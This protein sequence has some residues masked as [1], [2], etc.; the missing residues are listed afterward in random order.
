MFLLTVFYVAIRH[1]YS[2]ERQVQAEIFLFYW[3]Y[4]NMDVKKAFRVAYFEHSVITFKW[5]I[6]AWKF[7]DQIVELED[8]ASFGSL[9]FEIDWFLRIVGS[10]KWFEYEIFWEFDEDWGSLYLL[11]CRSL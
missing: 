7:Q 10:E 2:G 1:A 8:S 5:V 6:V 4:A 11:I 9:G 3:S